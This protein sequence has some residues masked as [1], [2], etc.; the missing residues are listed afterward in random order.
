MISRPDAT[1]VRHGSAGRLPHRIALRGRP[2]GR[3]SCGTALDPEFLRQ[4]RWAAAVTPR[5]R[6]RCPCS[7]ASPATRAATVIGRADRLDML[8]AA[9]VNAAS[10]NVFDFDDTHHPT[11][12][13]PTAPVAPALFALAETRP[14]TGAALL[15][16]FILGVEIECRLG[17]AVSPW[18]YRHGW[19]ITSTCGAFGA[20]AA[21]AGSRARPRAHD[22]GARQRVGAIVRPGRDARHDGEEHRCRRRGARRAFGRVVRTGRRHRPGRADRRAA[23]LYLCDGRCA[24]SRRITEGL[25]ETWEIMANTH[26]PYPCGVVL[27]PVIDACLELRARNPGL[28]RAAIASIDG[29]RPFAAARARGP[30]RGHH[31]AGSAGQRAA[32]RRG[33]ADPR[34]GRRH[35]VRGCL[36]DQ[37]RG[38]CVAPQGHRGGASRHA[39]RG[40]ACDD[41]ARGRAGSVVL[42]RAGRGTPQRP[43]SDAE[44]EAKVRELARY[45]C[46]RLDPGPLIEAVWSL[47]SAPIRARSCNS[48]PCRTP[49][50]AR[51]KMRADHRLDRGPRLRHRAGACGGGLQHHAQRHRAGGGG[52]RRRARRSRRAPGSPRLSS[53]PTSPSCGRSSV[54]S[55]KRLRGSAASTSWSIMRWCATS[56]RSS[57][58]RRRS[59][60][61]RWRSTCRRRFTWCAWRF[62]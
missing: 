5:S 28:A 19:H 16:A 4:R 24:R 29:R 42:R 38:S 10:G 30:A 13:H 37:R 48:Q 46:P 50:D 49:R 58:S 39:G 34:R 57:N 36:R 21:A 12:I 51:R 55:A 1:S 54:W 22:L 56:R 2:A 47:E 62:R 40:R 6:A 25:G 27:F 35:P 43:M 3:S 18:H 61:S 20:A 32:Q 41:H 44:I 11:I 15:H 7:T 33:R 23:R 52:R 60:S 9:F 45:G 53:R 17:N 8:S 59:G 14:M 31:R 26:K